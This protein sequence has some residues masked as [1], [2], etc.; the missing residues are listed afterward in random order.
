MSYNAFYLSMP[1]EKIEEVLALPKDEVRIFFFDSFD[2][3]EVRADTGFWGNELKEIIERCDMA[4]VL[5]SPSSTNPKF[6]ERLNETL[7][8][9]YF[10]DVPTTVRI[11]DD[12]AETKVI[13]TDPDYMDWTGEITRILKRKGNEHLV[14]ELIGVILEI[15][16]LFQYAKEKGHIVINYWG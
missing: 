4:C 10:F 2:N 5:D 6:T 3:A 11:A 7:G 13:S 16:R 12:L 14:K 15:T 8:E 1:P 9:S